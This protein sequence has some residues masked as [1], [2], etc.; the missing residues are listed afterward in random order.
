M[1]ADER[2]LLHRH[3][4][5]KGVCPQRAIGERRLAPFYKQREREGAFDGQTL[6]EMLDRGFAG[7]ITSGLHH[8]KETIIAALNGWVIGGGID[9]ALACDIRVAPIDV[10]RASEIHLVNRVVPQAVLVATVEEIASKIIRNPRVAV[11]S[12]KGTILE[13]VGRPIGDPEIVAKR[14]EFLTHGD[15]DRATS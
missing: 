6:R 4:R 12:A 8:I 10:Q 3:G 7:G 9:L 5:A 2:P 14:N 15:E 13:V 11:E 1:R